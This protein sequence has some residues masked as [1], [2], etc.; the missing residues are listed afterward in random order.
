M[1]VGEFERMKQNLEVH[2]HKHKHKKK[3]QDASKQAQAKAAKQQAEIQA[4]LRRD[5]E[6]AALRRKHPHVKHPKEWNEHEVAAWLGSVQNGKYARYKDTF[7]AKE[8]DGEDFEYVDKEVLKDY[9]VVKPAHQVGI[10]RAI[11]ELFHAHDRTDN[12]DDTTEEMKTNNANQNGN[13]TVK[14][15]L[16]VAVTIDE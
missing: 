13:K 7:I 3:A 11:R 12:D 16:G 15:A 5:Q 2:T 4:K 1:A 8:F 6:L 9:N 10:L 14:N